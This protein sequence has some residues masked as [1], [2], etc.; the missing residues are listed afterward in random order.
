MKKIILGLWVFAMTL[1]LWAQ[2]E[3]TRLIN[4]IKK[5]SHLYLYGDVTLS[6]P[7]VAYEVALQELHIC[8]GSFVPA[9]VF[10]KRVIGPQIHRHRFPA[11]RT[12]GNKT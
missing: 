4:N 5:E 6:T 9:F 11:D 8:R 1:P 2:S 12:V 3:Q 7:E 10:H